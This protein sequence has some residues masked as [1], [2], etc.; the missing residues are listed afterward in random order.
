MSI[1]TGDIYQLGEHLLACG[2]STDETFVQQ[3]VGKTSV[4]LVL[5]DPPYGVSYVESKAGLN[6]KLDHKAIANDH[7]QSEEEYS[8]FTAN[9]IKPILTRLTKK[10]AFYIFNQDKMLFPLREGMISQ[11]VKFSQLL[12][13]VKNHAVV[14]RLD[15]LPQHELIIYGWYG[16]HKFYKSKDKSVLFYPKPSKSKLHPT[17]KPVGLLRQLVLNSS[18][19]NDVVYEPF[20]GSGSTLIACEQTKR[21]C[22]AIELDPEYCKVII[23]RFQKLTGIKAKKL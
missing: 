5:T 14:G 22:I 20:A 1:N 7:L 23:D 8:E 13:W 18:T 21:K 17:M 19:I 3:V 10:N 9:W 12:I 11:G 2:S 16:T 15:Y 4:S 6:L